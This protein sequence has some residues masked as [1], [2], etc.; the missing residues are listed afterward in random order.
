MAHRFESVP[1]FVKQGERFWAA[2]EG[3]GFLSVGPIR[4]QVAHQSQQQVVPELLAHVV[5]ASLK[6]RSS[7]LTCGVES[8][9]KTKALQ[10]GLMTSDGLGHQTANEVM[11]D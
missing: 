5:A 4:H 3:A 2:F 11:A 7:V 1:D 8:A 9:F 6:H 10:I